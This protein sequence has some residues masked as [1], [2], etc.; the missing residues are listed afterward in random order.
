M[1]LKKIRWMLKAGTA[2]CRGFDMREAHLL[3]PP[4]PRKVSQTQTATKEK[5]KMTTE[6]TGDGGTVMSTAATVEETAAERS[7]R[8][9][10]E[11]DA[12]YRANKKARA[13]DGGT[14]YAAA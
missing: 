9:K 10:R 6:N 1:L 11:R 2:M 7:R 12:R 3:F 5:V 13:G 8:L 14:V 4:E